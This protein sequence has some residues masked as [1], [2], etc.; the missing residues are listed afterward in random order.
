MPTLRNIAL[1]SPYMHNGGMATLEQVITF[2]SRATN[3]DNDF[4]HSFL[5]P[6]STLQVDKDARASIVAFL[7]TL[8]DDRVV[9]E[10]APFDHPELIIG[11]GHPGDNTKVNSGSFVDSKLATDDLVTLPAVGAEGTTTPQQRFEDNLAD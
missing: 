9:Y 11:H 4:K 6:S 10:K 7:N 8:T 2:Y 1:T 5:I 3:F